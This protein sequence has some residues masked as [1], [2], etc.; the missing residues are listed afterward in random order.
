[1]RPN[2][3]PRAACWHHHHLLHKDPG[4]RLVLDPT[5]RRLDV[6]YHDRP[7]R[8]DRTRRGGNEPGRLHAGPSVSYRRCHTRP[9]HGRR[10]MSREVFAC[11][12]AQVGACPRITSRRR[13]AG[14]EGVG[15]GRRWSIASP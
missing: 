2:C 10:R 9:V 11:A 15:V 6:Y 7:G 8:L 14:P 13:R 3:Q 12:A 5:T 1:M 4:W